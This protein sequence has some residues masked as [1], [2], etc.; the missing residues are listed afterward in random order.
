M[1]CPRVEKAVEARVG[2]VWAL[3]PSLIHSNR[4]GCDAS[5]TF[6][7]LI[8]DL[9]LLNAVNFCSAEMDDRFSVANKDC[10]CSSMINLCAVETSKNKDLLCHV[11]VYREQGR[12]R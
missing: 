5:G 8:A 1:R 11:N 6:W 12:W 2:A 9:R 3:I 10:A 4:T 7:C